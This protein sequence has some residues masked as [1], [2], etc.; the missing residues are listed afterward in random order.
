MKPSI[1]AG[2]RYKVTSF[3]GKFCKTSA[4]LGWF[5]PDPYTPGPLKKDPFVRVTA[6]LVDSNQAA[7]YV[8]EVN[9]CV[10]TYS[11]DLKNS[12]PHFFRRTESSRDLK[13]AANLGGKTSL[14]ANVSA[15]FRKM[16][17]LSLITAQ[18]L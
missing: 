4:R 2:L 13:K 6:F 15:G 10:G 8:K 7:K 16:R 5:S 18:S 9:R 17:Y 14:K 12:I 11:F 3:F 1:H